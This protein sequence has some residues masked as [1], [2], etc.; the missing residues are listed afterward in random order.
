VVH[1]KNRLIKEDFVLGPGELTENRHKNEPLALGDQ[2]P[3]V[4]HKAK[5]FN[6]YDK[7]GNKW[8]D[9][10]SGIFTANAGHANDDI[11][12]AIKA[13]LDS[14][15]L[16]AYQYETTIR[17]KF[18][19]KL[20]DITP[21][22]LNK[23]ILLNTGS[24]A[25][26]AIYRLLKPWARQQNKKY[27]ICFK[28]SYHGR[29]LGSALMGGSKF[30]TMWSGVKDEDI[31][32]IDFPYHK[33][34]VFEP[35]SLP[36]KEQ[37]AAFFLE[38]YQGWGACMYPPQYIKSLYEYAREIGAL[39]C[40]DEVQAGFYRMGELFGFMTYGDY[41]EPD[42]IS[43]GKGISSCLPIAAVLGRA[44][45][46][47]LDL[48]ANLSGTHAG[49]AICCA[50]SLANLEFLTDSV[51]QDELKHKIQYFEQRCKKLLE[52]DLVHK[53]NY[54]GMVAGIIL[55]STAVANETVTYC[56]LNGV[57]P[58]CTFR[59]SIKLGPP[60]TISLDAIEEAFDV[61]ESAIMEVSH[62]KQ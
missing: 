49:N 31:I 8:I 48:D 37:I 15:L 46:I 30:D 50:A 51:F 26:D 40:F 9:M 4:W 23:A 14:D 11:K 7:N 57:L 1:T 61:I 53:V 44:D 35:Q 28:G 55:K 43:V 54:R 38:T 39:V 59:E 62:V 21:K 60:L 47:D 2:V 25:T 17:D 32:F 36:P 52:L 3:I 22:H 41:I 13:Q 12:N 18:V 5:D 58:V 27:I 33:D 19:T 24:E 10:T 6:V 42:L 45:I 20:L 16:F 56:L 29:V 34:D